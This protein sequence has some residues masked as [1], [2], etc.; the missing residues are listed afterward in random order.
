[1]TATIEERYSN[2]K[3]TSTLSF[4]HQKNACQ[5]VTQHDNDLL[6]CPYFT[7]GISS[8]DS[9]EFFHVHPHFIS[10]NMH[11]TSCVNQFYVEKILNLSHFVSHIS[12]KSQRD[13]MKCDNATKTTTMLSE[14]FYQR[15]QSNRKYQISHF[16]TF[17]IV[18]RH[19]F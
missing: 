2:F 6:S 17:S 4:H 8:R 9:E 12:H 3:F 11:I 15:N 13:E 10:S 1:M 16:K 5:N 7:L 19:E 18:L 14:N